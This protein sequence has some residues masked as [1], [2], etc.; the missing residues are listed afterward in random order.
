M[1]E[2]RTA[3]GKQASMMLNHKEFCG[4][5]HL[6]HKKSQYQTQNCTY[7]NIN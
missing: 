2:I 4:Q 3:N 5:L 1:H 6:Q 7:T